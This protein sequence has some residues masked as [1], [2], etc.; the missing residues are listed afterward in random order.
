VCIGR[1]GPIVPFVAAHR[2]KGLAL[3]LVVC[4][5]LLVPALGTA[6]DAGTRIVGGDVAGAGEYPWQVE[7]LKESSQ[8]PAG[9]FS[10]IC[11]GTL[12]AEFQVLTAAHCTDFVKRDNYRVRVGSQSRGAGTLINVASH[13]EHPQFDAATLANDASVLQ[14]AASGTVGGG[15][16]LQLIDEE[17]PADDAHW[18][19]GDMLAISGWGSTCFQTCGS[20]TQ[21]RE[22]E[23]P[24]VADTTCDN[25][26]WYGSDFVP[27]TMVCAGFDEGGVD[28]CQGDSGGPLAAS[29]QDPLP[30]SAS[31][32]AQWR[33]VGITSWG[34]ECAE[35]NKPGVYTR[36]A[37]PGIRDWILGQVGTP[38]PTFPLT[39]SVAGNGTVTS[40]PG[41]I[42][43]PTID[44]SHSYDEGE[45]VLLTA[46]A[47]PGE[48]FNGWGGNCSGSVTQECTV[49]MTVSRSVSAEFSG[50]TPVPTPTHTL[51]VTKAGTGAGT[52]TSSPTGISCGPVCMHDYDEGDDVTLTASAA[53]GSTFSGWSGACSGTPCVV[54]MDGDRGVAATFNA[55]PPSDDDPVPTDPFTPDLDDPLDELDDVAPVASITSNR[56]RMS[57]RG[58]VR[59]RMDCGNP[60]DCLGEVRL[61]LRLPN[62]EGDTTMQNVGRAEFVI[63]AGE[64]KRVRVRLKRRARLH[65][66]REESVR[67]RVVALVEDAAGN[68]RKL[69]EKLTLRAA[70]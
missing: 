69:R 11:G 43:C 9:N 27:A 63:A 67:V 3:A 60:E 14:L 35:P 18:Q 21:L 23:V 57:R 5:V 26:D 10:F 36:V 6:Q 7:V 28:T 51:T 70:E 44:C 59:V 50:T 13:L 22:A 62:G 29:T 41:P 53:A 46:H 8:G 31:S 32:P 25:P 42:D 37:A 64:D 20:V 12:I 40:S 15:Q 38:A 61:R 55:K 48:T 24:R 39:V 65:V 68:T 33:L 34:F 58:Y 45:S 30:S 66:T 56:L 2:G 47:G 17:P 19:T 49:S 4:A 1:R 16:T 54:S 52:V